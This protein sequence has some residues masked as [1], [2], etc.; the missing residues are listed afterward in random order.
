METMHCLR[1]ALDELLRENA[2]FKCSQQCQRAFKEN[3]KDSRQI[4]ARTLS[5]KGSRG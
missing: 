2:K 3:K 4:I 1:A 5:R